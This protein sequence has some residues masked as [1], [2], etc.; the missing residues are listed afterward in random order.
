MGH[1][2]HWRG[3]PKDER[4]LK[5]GKRQISDCGAQ[6][7]EKDENGRK[8]GR[9]GRSASGM[10]DE[11][12][13]VPRGEGASVSLT[14]S[15]SSS[16]RSGRADGRSRRGA[17]SGPGGRSEVGGGG[18]GGVCADRLSGEREG[19]RD[20]QGWCGGSSVGATPLTALA[21]PGPAQPARVRARAAAPR[22]T[23]GFA[24]LCALSRTTAT[25][26]LGSRRLCLRTAERDTGTIVATKVGNTLRSLGK[27]LLPWLPEATCATARS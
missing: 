19:E 13:Q 7:E 25:P 26:P 3:A 24:R 1:Q 12:R 20:L 2:G 4:A 16:P 14:S 6:T 21:I 23:G 27:S 8:E 22:R 15:L 9:R 5:V 18:R 17:G 11:G 10:D